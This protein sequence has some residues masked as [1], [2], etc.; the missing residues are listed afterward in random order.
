[1][2]ENDNEAALVVDVAA[3][4]ATEA[5]IN[6]NE[7]RMKLQ[8]DLLKQS[9]KSIQEE[10]KSLKSHHEKKEQEIIKELEDSRKKIKKSNKK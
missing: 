10:C 6:E 5:A 4:E 3:G 8:I 2:E 1:V 7:T 9:L